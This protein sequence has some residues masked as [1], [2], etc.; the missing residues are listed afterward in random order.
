M[1]NFKRQHFQPKSSASNYWTR[2]GPINAQ[3]YWRG[4]GFSNT[5]SANYPGLFNN[6]VQ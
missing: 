3:P 4:T 6:Q 1:H 5:K 2:Y